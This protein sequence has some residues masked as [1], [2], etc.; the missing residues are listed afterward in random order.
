MVKFSGSGKAAFFDKAIRSRTLPRQLTRQ[1]VDVGVLGHVVPALY[2]R[3]SSPQPAVGEFKNEP[4]DFVAITGEDET[5][6]QRF[7]GNHP[8]DGLVAIDADG[9]T[10]KAFGL[11]F[12]PSTVLI[13]AEGNLAAITNPD[14]ADAAALRNL[15]AGETI[16]TA[17]AHWRRQPRCAEASRR[18]LTSALRAASSRSKAP[19]PSELLDPLNL[20]QPASTFQPHL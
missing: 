8:V 5:L 7:L 19:P 6:V 10:M 4:I 16:L 1:S 17:R 14:H 13:D 15:I 3:D 12:L 11:M 18:S 2:R 20:V 9:R